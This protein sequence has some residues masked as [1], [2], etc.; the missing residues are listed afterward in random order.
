MELSCPSQTD[1]NIVEEIN[2]RV[3]LWYGLQGAVKK[4]AEWTAERMD[5]LS[6]S[7][8]DIR[9]STALAALQLP[10]DAKVNLFVLSVTH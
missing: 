5:V 6:K 2:W 4:F 1:V 10:I 9:F 8:E 3:D 7:L